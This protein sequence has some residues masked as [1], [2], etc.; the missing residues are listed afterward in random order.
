[1]ASRKP[2]QS[3]PASGDTNEKLPRPRSLKELAAYLKLDPSTVSVVL[4]N[5][6]GRSISEPTRERIKAAAQMFNYRPS[7]LARSLR[8]KDTRTIG[9]LLPLVGE[10]YHAQVLSGIADELEEQKYHYLIAQHRHNAEALQE[11]AEILISRGVM[12]FVVIDTHLRNSLEVPVVAVAG[13]E[14]LAGVTNVTLDHE[15]AALDTMRHL[16]SLGHKKIAVIRGQPA[17]SDSAI[18]WKATAKAARQV[19]I[20]IPKEMSVQLKDNTPSPEHGYVVTQQ[21]LKQTNRFTALVCFNDFAALG[22]IRALE[23]AGLAVPRD[24]SVV[25][26]DDIRL[27]VFARPSITTVRQPLSE[28]GKSAAQ[29]LLQRLQGASAPAEFAVEP[30]LV[31]RESTAKVRKNLSGRS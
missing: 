7:L 29:I 14:H 16:K 30:K 2:K 23:D 12:G 5:V 9:I 21:L 20:E 3:A 8:Q 15:T 10:E 13:H 4:N 11:Y 31:V 26:F 19:G 27:S 28:M 1:M 24:V 25:G 18:R 22:A 17:S 6:P